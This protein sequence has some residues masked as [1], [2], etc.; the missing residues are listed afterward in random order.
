MMLEEVNIAISKQGENV[1]NKA[2]DNTG[3]TVA[4]HMD[5]Y[6]L[7]ADQ[8]K[9]CI[10][11]L[12]ADI[13]RY[14]SQINLLKAERKMFGVGLKNTESSVL[15]VPI[16]TDLLSAKQISDGWITELEAVSKAY[17]EEKKRNKL[18]QVHV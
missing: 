4:P 1:M 8:R 5:S 3:F 6:K 2:Q 14:L 13:S 9:E 17:D 10:M 18:L 11:N 16:P 15:L 12:E 7:L